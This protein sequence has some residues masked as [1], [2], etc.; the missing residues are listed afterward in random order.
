VD[1]YNFGLKPGSPAIGKGFT[2]FTALGSVPVHPKYG[3]TELTQTG[4]DIGAYQTNG[5][6]N[7]H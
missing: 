7:N 5:T 3:L 4:R 2:G 6:G 1:N